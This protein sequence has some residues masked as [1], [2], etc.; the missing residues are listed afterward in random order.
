MNKYPKIPTVWARDPDTPQDKEYRRG[1]EQARA[2]AERAHE[3]SIVA[4]GLRIDALPDAEFTRLAAIDPLPDWLAAI[5]NGK[6]PRT[7]KLVRARVAAQLA[8]TD[9][10]GG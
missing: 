6:D 5:N 7:S 3:E 10:A 2:N 4:M 8:R 9:A 1:L